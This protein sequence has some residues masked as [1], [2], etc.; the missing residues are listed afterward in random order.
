MGLARFERR[1]ERLV[2]GSFGKAF[3]SGIEPVEIGRRIA[4]VIDEE[5]TTGVDGTLIAPNNVGVYLSPADF[6][7]FHSFAETLARELAEL[8]RGHARDENYHFAGPVTVTL[9]PDD[10]LRVG[11]MDVAAQITEGVRVG[12]LVM[13]DGRRV[14]LGEEAILIGRLPECDIVVNDPRA[15]RRHAEI[16]PSG[17]GY[18]VTDLGSMNG[19]QVNGA[20]MRE[21]VLADGDQ[22]SIGKTV[23]TFEVS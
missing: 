13:P 23:L 2:E 5:V 8:T 7:R 14:Q 3:R 22:I 9:V 17:N 4:R 1:L 10:E 6:E 19:T 12:S 16:R 21:H 15:S 18:C 20:P 11:E